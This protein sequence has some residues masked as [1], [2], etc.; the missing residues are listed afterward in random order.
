[1]TLTKDMYQWYL[2]GIRSFSTSVVAP[3]RFNRIINDAQD[4]FVNENIG[5]HEIG[6]RQIDNLRVLLTEK[7]Y[8]ESGLKYKLPADYLRMS[9]VKI[10]FSDVDRCTVP[11]NEWLET[12]V[13]KADVVTSLNPY[14]KPSAKMRYHQFIGDS[15]VLYFS[16]AKLANEGIKLLYYKKPTVIYF[17]KLKQE[18][19]EHTNIGVPAYMPGGGSIPPLFP[20]EQCRMI[21]SIAVRVSLE[22]NQNPRYQSYL[23]EE[24]LRERRM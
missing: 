10:M 22:N 12:R 23:N 21:V 24:T 13:M 17:D 19:R 7:V 5:V 4:I 18:D 16:G 11:I 6:Q 1:M 2:D 15:I 8:K 20:E 9:S 3:E 14:R